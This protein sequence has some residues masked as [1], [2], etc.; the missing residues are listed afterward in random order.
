MNIEGR[1]ITDDRGQTYELERE[2]GRGGQGAVY[3]AKG[4]KRAIKILFDRSNTRRDLLRGQLQNI[5]QM[6]ELRN[7]AIACPLEMLQAPHLGYVMELITG[8]IPIAQ[9]INPPR[10]VDSLAEWYLDGGG[11][12]RR[13]ILL[14]RCAEVLAQLHSKGLVYSDPSPNNI[15]VSTDLDAYETRLIDADNLHYESSSSTRSFHTPGYG[16]PEL[17]LGK[18]GVNTLTD[19]HAFAVIAFQTLCLVH[20]LMGDLVLDNEPELEEKALEGSLPWVE[21]PD[22]QSNATLHGF[23]RDIVLSPKLKKLCQRCFSKGLQEP[24]KRPGISQ[25]VED[26]YSAA[27]FTMKCPDCSSTYYANQ[28]RCPWCDYPRPVFVELRIK[29]WE[30]LQ[31][32]REYKQYIKGQVGLACL[33][34]TEHQSLILTNRTVT[35]RTGIDS[36]IPAIELQIEKT[37]VRIRSLNG[38]CFWLS[39]FDDEHQVVTEVQDEW[40][41]FSSN[42]QHRTWLLH[43]APINCSHRLATFRF[44]SGGQSS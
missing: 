5:R 24:I 12:H 26:L 13:L 38:Q 35:G 37:N 41:R 20:P 10:S 34:V 3:A 44:I 17:V 15:F 33:V 16:A 6:H 28:N 40:K 43:F 36:H 31:E 23:P 27:D 2:L 19:A 8:M 14:A 39:S 11:L 29:R 22:D 30:P 7:L 25:W 18:S 32:A 4:G 42:D 9:L 1:R 21:D